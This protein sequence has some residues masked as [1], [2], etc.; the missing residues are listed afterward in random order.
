[1]MRWMCG[2]SRWDKIRNGNMVKMRNARVTLLD[3]PTY[4][5]T[6]HPHFVFID[7]LT[8]SLS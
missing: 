8:S 5:Q 3:T 4:M 7:L 6:R 2:K 1:M